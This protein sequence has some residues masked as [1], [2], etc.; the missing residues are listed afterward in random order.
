LTLQELAVPSLAELAWVIK[1][2]DCIEISF[3]PEKSVAGMDE[4]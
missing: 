1:A 3:K 4:Y 2:G